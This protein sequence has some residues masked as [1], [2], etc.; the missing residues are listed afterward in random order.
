MYFSLVPVDV[1]LPPDILLVRFSAIGDLLLTT[2]LIRTLRARYPDARLTFVTRQRFASLLCDNRHLNEIVELPDGE[3]VWRLA[4]QLK[5]RRFTH[6]LDLHG[7]LRSRAL[8]TLVPGAWTG[9]SKRRLAR[10]L[11]I[12]T[13][14]DRYRDEVPVAERYFE[15]ARAAGLDVQPDGSG[16]EL[17]PSSSARDA[18]DA[19]L[20]ASGARGDRPVVALAPGAAHATKRWP[21]DHWRALASRLLAADLDLVLVGGP[22]DRATAAGIGSSIGPTTGG[23]LVDATGALAL[24]ETGAVLARAAALVSGD[25]GIMHMATAVGTPVVALFGPTVGQFGFF[26]Y[27]ARATVLE[28]DLHCRPCSAQGGTICPLGHHRCLGEILPD[29]VFAAVSQALG[30]VIARG[31]DGEMRDMSDRA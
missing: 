4:G 19:W 14:Q 5:G 24:Q 25:T 12:R 29:A 11:L 9:Y 21:A 31:G 6:R 13:K 2:P 23:R 27:R 16:L 26:P 1:A 18:A 10:A 20:A 8:R 3:S 30:G 28:R 7:S 22:D 15:A 17:T